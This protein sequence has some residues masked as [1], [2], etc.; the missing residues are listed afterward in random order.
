MADARTSFRGWITSPRNGP[1]IISHFFLNH[2]PT[3][4]LTQA[5]TLSNGET[6]S[7]LA[8]A[9]ATT[10]QSSHSWLV[11][12]L[13]QWEVLRRSAEVNIPALVDLSPFSF[14]PNPL[15]MGISKALIDLWT[16]LDK[17]ALFE[18]DELTRDI[19]SAY[20]QLVSRFGNGVVFDG[21]AWEDQRYYHARSLF[22]K[23]TGY[24]SVQSVTPSNNLYIPTP[25]P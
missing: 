10:P 18:W 12:K 1:S 8:Y 23:W 15:T 25:W 14:P 6:L 24:Q 2:T 3:A 5:N 7:T 21:S 13:V 22:F 9:F 16:S 19:Q 11:F 17:A 20:A 4:D